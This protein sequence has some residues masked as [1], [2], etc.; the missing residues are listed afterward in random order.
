MSVALVVGVPPELWNLCVACCALD[1]SWTFSVLV[2]ILTGSA[3]VLIGLG[4]GLGE[5]ANQGAVE[6]SRMAT[7]QLRKGWM[8]LSWY[9]L[10]WAVLSTSGGV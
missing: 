4:A 3:W 7:L 8:T 2:A 1:G 5:D 9:G 6:L 10:I